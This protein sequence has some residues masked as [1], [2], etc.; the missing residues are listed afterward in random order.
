[1]SINP[2][3]PFLGSS[4]ILILSICLTAIFI[5]ET[6]TTL[7]RKST[8]Q[9]C[10][11]ASIISQEQESQAPS[12]PFL[13]HAL[14][15]VQPYYAI[16]KQNFGVAL[17]LLSFFASDLGSQVGVVLLQYTSEKFHW[18]FAKVS[19]RSSKEC[20]EMPRKLTSLTQGFISHFSTCW[21]KSV[22]PHN[23]DSCSLRVCPRLSTIS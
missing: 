6:S 19:L 15:I 9:S 13:V 5:P 1:M 18:S 12:R 4:I 20:V 3:I 8:S 16:V 10:E 22:C 11:G 23:L 21:C 2:W 7:K 17:I 14:R